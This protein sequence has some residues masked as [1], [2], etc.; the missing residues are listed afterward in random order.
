MTRMVFAI[1]VWTKV[2]IFALARIESL[3][4][5]PRDVYAIHRGMPSENLDGIFDFL[6]IS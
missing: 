4:L 5:S 2:E 1:V 6:K 3:S